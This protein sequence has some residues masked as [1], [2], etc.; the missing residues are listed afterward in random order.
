MCRT[1]TIETSVDVCRADLARVNAKLRA[2]VNVAISS[3]L[4][5]DDARARARGE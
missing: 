5:P 4:A 2:T 3:I 1:E